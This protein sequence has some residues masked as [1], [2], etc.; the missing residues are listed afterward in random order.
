MVSFRK[1]EGILVQIR[2]IHILVTIQ[3]TM[4]KFGCFPYLYGMNRYAKFH[5][6]FFEN[7]GFRPLLSVLFDVKFPLIIV[8]R[9]PSSYQALI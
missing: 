7:M 4:L 8:R 9:T 2:D 3:V 6:F 1:N 5:V